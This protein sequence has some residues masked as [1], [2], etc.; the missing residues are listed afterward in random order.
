MHGDLGS[1]CISEKRALQIKNEFDELF[2]LYQQNNTTKE[3]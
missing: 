1:I 2:N 3:G